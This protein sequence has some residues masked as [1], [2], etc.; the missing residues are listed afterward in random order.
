MSH[1]RFDIEPQNVKKKPLCSVTPLKRHKI[2][3]CCVEQKAF[4]NALH[5]PLGKE[6]RQHLLLGNVGFPEAMIY[7]SDT[8][9]CLFIWK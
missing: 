8:L 2:R 5:L 7:P 6:E 1:Q 4:L 3:R 9:Y